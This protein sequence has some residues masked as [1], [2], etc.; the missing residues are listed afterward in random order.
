MSA[1]RGGRRGAPRRGGTL[2]LVAVSVT[3]L[4][5]IAA[6]AVDFARLYVVRA[7]LRTLADAAS[8]SGVTDLGR[9]AA[10]GDAV[11]RAL[12][13]R[14]GNHVGG[15]PLGDAGFGAADLAPGTWDFAARQFTAAP[16]GEA[17]A[18]RATARHTPPWTLGRVFGAANRTL[19]ATTVAALGSPQWRRCLTPWAVPYSNILATLGRSPTDTAYRLTAADVARLRDGQ[20]PIAFKVSSK[21][22]DLGGATVAGTAIGGNYYVV[23]LPPVQY[24]DGSAGAPQGGASTYRDALSTTTCTGTARSAGV[25]D[26]L[27]LE[28]GNMVGPTRQGV[29]TLCGAS[30]NSFPCNARVTLPVWNA[31]NGASA[32]AWVQVLYVGAFV[33]TGFNNG[34]VTGYLTALLADGTASGFVPRPGPV[35]RGA[36]VQ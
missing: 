20:V 34:S 23:R 15:A 31:R 29:E 9:G 18:V 16:W 4:V 32:S 14:A 35:M 25:G 28:S 27:D 10:Q 12:A 17:N 13:L 11:A 8:L 21:T 22:Q 19:T 5:A 7:Q 36:L 6:L 1:A 33:V 24:A 30:G 2:V 26:W 3:L